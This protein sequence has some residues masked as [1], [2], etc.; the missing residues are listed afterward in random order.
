MVPEQVRLECE[1]LK[2]VAARYVM[3]SAAATERYQQ[4]RSLILELVEA[5][6][7]E[8]QRGSSPDLLEPALRTSYAAAGIDHVASLTD[9]SAAVLHRRLTG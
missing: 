1:V 7:V 2:A 9:R 8:A 5:L 4:Q 3:D 6:L